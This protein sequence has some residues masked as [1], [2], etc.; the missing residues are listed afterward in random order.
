[1]IQQ[2]YSWVFTEEHANMCPHQDVKII[3][4]RSFIQNNQKLE[5]NAHLLVDE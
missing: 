2:F 4:H 3:L 5:T 1:M